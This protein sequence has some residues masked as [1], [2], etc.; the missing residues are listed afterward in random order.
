[1][2]RS[3]YFVMAGLDPA[4]RRDTKIGANRAPSRQSRVIA[5]STPG[6]SPGAAMT[7][8]GGIKCDSPGGT[9][10]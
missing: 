6:S 1:M 4:I 5:G 7:M 3:F 2:A 8:R 10:G 9:G